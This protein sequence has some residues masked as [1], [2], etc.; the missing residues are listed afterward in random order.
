MSGEVNSGQSGTGWPPTQ[1][2]PYDP[3]MYGYGAGMPGMYGGM[4]GMPYGM[5]G[6]GM[7]PFNSGFATPYSP[8]YSP[9]ATP[10]EKVNVQN[11]VLHAQHNSTVPWALGGAAIGGGGG[12]LVT[13]GAAKALGAKAGTALKI[14]GAGGVL[15]MVAGLAGG[16][17]AGTNLAGELEKNRVADQWF[18]TNH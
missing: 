10:Y 6:Y 7:G 14:G 3:S 9:G 13:A 16:F 17:Y 5:G 4:Y 15:G 2:L 1:Q 11:D 8:M 18:D 12:F